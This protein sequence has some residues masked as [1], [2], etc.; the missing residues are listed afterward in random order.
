M[1][2]GVH[3]ESRQECPK[4]QSGGYD[5]TITAESTKRDIVTGKG[6]RGSE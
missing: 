5:R 4:D 1:A 2:I 6:K 3:V